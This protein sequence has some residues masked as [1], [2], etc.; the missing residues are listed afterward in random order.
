MS[1]A[2]TGWNISDSPYK[3]TKTHKPGGTDALLL[4][5]G[6][7]CTALFES[8]HPFSDKPRQ[9]LPKFLVPSAR[10]PR[11]FAAQGSGDT[12][13]VRRGPDDQGTLIRDPFWVG[14]LFDSRR[15]EKSSQADL[16]TPFP[17]NRM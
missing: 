6:R 15:L 7:D 2:W 8:Y 9:L 17:K 10:V 12:F 3:Y 14:W 11:E 16:L 13:Y 1:F 4:A 5:R